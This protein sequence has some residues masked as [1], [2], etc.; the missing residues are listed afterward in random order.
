M[1]ASPAELSVIPLWRAASLEIATSRASGPET[2]IWFPNAVLLP[3]P[4]M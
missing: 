1:S 2:D 4:P 3:A